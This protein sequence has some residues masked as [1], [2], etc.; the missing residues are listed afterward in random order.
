MKRIFQVVVCFMIIMY[1]FAADLFAQKPAASQPRGPVHISRPNKTIPTTARSLKDVDFSNFSYPGYRLKSGKYESNE[2]G[3][4]ESAELEKV[5]IFDSASGQPHRALVYVVDTSGGGSSNVEGQLFVFDF[6]NGQLTLTQTLSFDAQADGAGVKFDPATAKLVIKARSWSDGSPHCCPKNLDVVTFN[7]TPAGFSQQSVRIEPISAAKGSATP[8]TKPITEPK[9][10]R[11]GPVPPPPPISFTTEEKSHSAP[12]AAQYPGSIISGLDVAGVRLGMTP[13]EVIAALK[14]FDPE[15][16]FSKRYSDDSGFQ[17]YHYASCVFEKGGPFEGR[18]HA[19]TN[20]IAFKG[21]ALNGK[22]VCSEDNYKAPGAEE[23]M[24]NVYFSPDSGSH[25]VIAVILKKRFASPKMK[26]SLLDSALRK[27]PELLTYRSEGRLRWLFDG[28]GRVMS[29]KTARRLW[30]GSPSWEEDSYSSVGLP[31]ELNYE[32]GVSLDFLIPESVAKG[33]AATSNDA[34]A[35]SMRV[36]LYDE[37]AVC[38][39]VTTLKELSQQF[40][41][42][43]RQ[44]EIDRVKSTNQEVKF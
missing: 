22:S 7:W 26:N 34:L 8:K 21:T 12:A 11:T 13:T 18:F 25:R 30:W 3:G 17:Q 14:R 6:Q 24:V 2:D 42:R 5:W 20:I 38:R 33:S 23:E 39:F 37:N 40:D 19:F 43:Q 44:S 9:K 36:R 28:R 15:L 1:M 29:D 10:S 27:Y 41:A 16:I 4:F 31:T 35:T 32:N